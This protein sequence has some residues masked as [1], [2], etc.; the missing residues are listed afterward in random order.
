MSSPW[1]DGED[2][3][4]VKMTT[5]IEDR[6]DALETDVAEF[7]R[8]GCRVRR[9]AN[10]SIASGAATSISWDTEDEDTDGL[11]PGPGT[12]ITIP[13]ASPGL[14]A[15]TFAVSCAG[16]TGAGGALIIDPTSAITGMPADFL[17]PLDETRDRGTLAVVTPFA[18]GDTFVAQVFHAT[19]SNINFTAWLACYRI[20]L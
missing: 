14:Y 6:L 8:L 20:G 17:T 1:V 13:V 19:G 18:G 10:Q 12:T 5:R 16:I 3:N 4:A 11:L 9:A 2:V 7:A 15:I